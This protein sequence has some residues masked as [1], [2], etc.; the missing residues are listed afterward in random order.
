[1]GGELMLM[2]IGGCFMSNL[3]AAVGEAAGSTLPASRWKS[4]PTLEIPRR[5][6]SPTSCCRVTGG[7]TDPAAL[8]EMI[9]KA[10]AGCIA[11]NTAKGATGVTVMPA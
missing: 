2:G 3:L 1:M 4:P 5:R 6:G 10:E 11:I 9:A 7:N 8:N